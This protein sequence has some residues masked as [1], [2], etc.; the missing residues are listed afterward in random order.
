MSDAVAQFQKIIDDVARS[1]ALTPDAIRQFDL[2]RGTVEDLQKALSAK[3]EEIK[4]LQKRFSDSEQKCAEYKAGYESVLKDKTELVKLKDEAQKAVWIAEFE[5]QRR[6]EMRSIVGDVFRN[7][8]VRRNISL[9]SPVVVPPS[10][11]G[12]CHQIQYASDTREETEIV[13]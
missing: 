12:G 5:K 10:Y 13:K 2:M 3:T 6:E 1:G 7:S 8:E 9:S 11:P 4:G